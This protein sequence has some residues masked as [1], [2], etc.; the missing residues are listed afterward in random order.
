M[1]PVYAFDYQTCGRGCYSEF[2]GPASLR[3]LT[4]CNAAPKFN[5]LRCCYFGFSRAFASC[6]SIRARFTAVAFF[7]VAVFGILFRSSQEQVRW[8]AAAGYIALVE[9]PKLTLNGSV[10]YDVC[11]TVRRECLAIV[12]KSAVAVFVYQ[13]AAPKPTVTLNTA[14]D[15]YTCPEL[16]SLF[17]RKRRRAFRRFHVFDFIKLTLRGAS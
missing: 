7:A 17:N 15:I 14:G 3:A 8:I 5:N 1:L 16:R 12:N 2:F 6:N 13:L 9:N 11:N 10:F 4:R